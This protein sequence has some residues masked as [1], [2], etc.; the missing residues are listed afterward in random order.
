[1]DQ[2]LKRSATTPEL[3]NST[4]KPERAGQDRIFQQL[5][6]Q[7]TWKRSAFE[8]AAETALKQAKEDFKERMEIVMKSSKGYKKP[9]KVNSDSNPPKVSLFAKI[10]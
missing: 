1:M 8:E 3:L 4:E 7:V 9:K 6:G 2:S 5:E 10:F